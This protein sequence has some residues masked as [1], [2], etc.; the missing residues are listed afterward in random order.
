MNPK[1]SVVINTLNEEKNLPYAL[2][3]VQMWADE[4]VVVDMHSED[5]T[6]EIAKSY[7]AKTFLHERTGFVEPARAY[8][9]AQAQSEWVLILDADEMIPKALSLKI[10][11]IAKL[12]QA[13]TVII[14]RLNYMLGAPLY[15]SG[16]GPK[17][18]SH[19]RFF[20]KGMLST[21]ARI[22]GALK[23]SAQARVVELP[24]KPG[25]AIVHFNYIDLEQFLSKLN[26]YT[27]IE[28]QQARE[29][30][31][32]A[33][34]VK[35]LL[36]AVLEFFNRYIR[37]RGYKDGWRGFFLSG[38]MAT[39]RWATYAKLTELCEVGNNTHIEQIYREEAEK[40]LKGYQGNG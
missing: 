21:H 25:E 13:D 16:W 14:P 32:G 34:Q 1:I 26:R 10:L 2:R 6:I 3:S 22:H 17:Q 11:E 8:A 35:A 29:R 12:E 31:E 37:K 36:L 15:H 18:D 4:I 24:I 20:R 5:R 33:S 27:T 19:A 30:G 39:Y 23:P 9:I 38:L 28:A 7:G 40:W